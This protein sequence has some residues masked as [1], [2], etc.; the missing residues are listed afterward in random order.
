MDIFHDLT[1][2]TERIMGYLLKNLRPADLD[3]LNRKIKDLD[4]TFYSRFKM[5]SF[6]IYKSKGQ[7]LFHGT[8]IQ[9]LNFV[10]LFSLL[11][12]YFKKDSK[13][14]EIYSQFK[15]ILVFVQS[16]RFD[17]RELPKFDILVDSFIKNFIICFPNDTMTFKVHH[18]EHYKKEIC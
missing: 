14:F 4:K 10:I 11:N 18:I 8:G 16:P 17:R 6:K 9:K 2:A 5:S 7:I 3:T 15:K 1:G 13:E 12:T